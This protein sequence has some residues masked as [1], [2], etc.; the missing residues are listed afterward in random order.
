MIEIFDE[1][2]FCVFVD[3]CGLFLIG[4][5]LLVVIDDYLR[6]FVVEV[7]WFIFVRFVIFLFDKIF[8]L[9]GILEELKMDNGLLF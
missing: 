2:W 4:E 1:F 6:Y 8:L 3:F 5:Y 9:F 7:L